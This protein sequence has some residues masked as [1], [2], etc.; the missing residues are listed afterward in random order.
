[1]DQNQS[2]VVVPEFILAFQSRYRDPGIMYADELAAEVMSLIGGEPWIMV[3]DDWKRL[4]PPERLTVTDDQ[5][6]L[7][8]GLR[9]YQFAGPLIGGQSFVVGDG[10]RVQKGAS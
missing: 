2:P 9:R 10:H 7:Y 1:M 3:D 5:G 6:F 4:Q 8:Q